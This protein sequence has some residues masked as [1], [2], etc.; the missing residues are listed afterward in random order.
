MIVEMGGS[1]HINFHISAKLVPH[2]VA[3]VIGRHVD[4]M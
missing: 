2:Q 3:C 1:F 4:S